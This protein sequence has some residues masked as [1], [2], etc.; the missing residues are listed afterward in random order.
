MLEQSQYFLLND[1]E[2]FHERIVKMFLKQ[3][4]IILGKEKSSLSRN[5]IYKR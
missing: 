4:G 5:S 1:I 3:T 2:F